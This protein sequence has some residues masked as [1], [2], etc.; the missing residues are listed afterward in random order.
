MTNIVLKY[1]IGLSLG[2]ICGVVISNTTGIGYIGPITA[3]IVTFL[4]LELYDE[5][6]R[7]R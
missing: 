3:F 4:F 7:Y 5:L 6:D 2:I 1:I